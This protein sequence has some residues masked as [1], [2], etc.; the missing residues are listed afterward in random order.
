M[1]PAWAAA[2]APNT[3]AGFYLD[4]RAGGKVVVGFTGEQAAT[5]LAVL[6][7]TA[8]LMAGPERIIGFANPPQHT[9]AALEALRPQVSA[10]T[11]GYPAGLV[12][13]VR[14]DVRSNSVKVG[15]RNVGQAIS[16]L[17]GSFGAQAPITVDYDRYGREQMAGR[18][19]TAGPIRAGDELMQKYWALKPEEKEEE[20]VGPCTASFGAFERAKK[21]ATGEP[22]LR[23]FALTAAHCAGPGRG[24]WRR[25]NTNTN[26]DPKGDT[27][28]EVRRSGFVDKAIA[29]LD[30]DA[31]AIRL[32]NPNLV[33][34]QIFQEAGMP[35]K[36]VTSVWSPS[37]GT[38]VCFSGRSSQQ[39]RCGP[40]VSLPEDEVEHDMQTIEMCFKAGIWGGDSGSPVWVQGTGVAV[41]IATVGSPD[42]TNP[43]VRHEI[44][45]DVKE[46]IKEQEEELE[47][48]AEP[49]EY[50]ERLNEEIESA[51]EDR[52][53]CFT[54][55]KPQPGAPADATVFGDPNL[56]PLHLVTVTNAKS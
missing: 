33:P 37:L 15:A 8:G 2:Y 51:L 13:S 17:Q 12:N 27:I 49:G 21:P 9:L 24:I 53:T 16:L 29:N 52:E 11:A 44:E 26:G 30:T 3:F 47:E 54:L 56:A 45:D 1:I 25:D 31:A 50:E 6:E 39:R 40:I 43:E 14:A 19:R 4:E 23:L 28:G 46:D 34:R 36:N 42:P 32:E 5:S 7:Q 18:Q 20:E 41:G 48:P 35:L 38:N 10:A 22:V 55:L